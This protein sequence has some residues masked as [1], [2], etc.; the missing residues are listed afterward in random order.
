MSDWGPH[1]RCGRRN[2]SRSPPRSDM[3]HDGGVKPRSASASAGVAR[4]PWWGVGL[5]AVA[6][7]LGV[8]G[9][10]FAVIQPSTDGGPSSI[11]LPSPTGAAQVRQS[12][13]TTSVPTSIPAVRSTTQSTIVPA[14][15]T[16]VTEV[17]GQVATTIPPTTT[18]TTSVA[19]PTTTST[20]DDSKGPPT[21]EPH[22]RLKRSQ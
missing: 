20:T 8:A 13:T 5:A 11:R 10:A 12:A 15:R 22:D 2:H 7:A 3:R 4:I 9:F 19:S 1:V 14:N 6:T 18:P 16:V 17:S 21:T